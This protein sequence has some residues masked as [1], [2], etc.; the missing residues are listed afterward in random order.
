MTDVP[1]KRYQLLDAFRGLAILW[2][3]CF[4][5]LADVREQYGTVLNYI[6]AKGYLGV[7]IF[8]VISGY[9]V[10]ASTSHGT[11]SRKPLSFL[12]RRLKRIY[13]PYWWHL[14]FAVLVIPV[15][16][17]LVSMIK[18][19]TF[20]ISL[21]SYSILD[22][23]QIITLVKIFSAVNWK[24]N[25]AFLPLNGVVWY[26]AI[27]VQMYLF[28][29]ICFHFKKYYSS[30]LVVGFVASL[31]TNFTTIKETL[32]YGIFFP[33]FPQFCIG[34]F[35]FSLLRK[36]LVPE[37]KLSK[38]VIMLLG[39]GALYYCAS[40]EKELLSLSFAIVTGFIF[41][42]MHKYDSSLSRS[43]FVRLLYLMGTFSFSLYLLHVPL[44]PFVG[45][46][47]RNLVPLPYILSGP[48]IL[49]PGIIVLSFFWYLFFERP[50]T[51]QEIVNCIFCPIHTIRSGVKRALTLVYDR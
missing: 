46:F 3:V 15:L 32:P 27:I 16:S 8:F 49:V 38:T 42:I 20:D 7:S 40:N 44:W 12:S 5:V 37:T 6:I 4:H 35:V 51:Q 30:L 25:V 47:V 24:L 43:F 34:V 11:Y 48:F 31:L 22:W 39:I 9:G 14:L 33:Y 10:A 26:L 13:F 21:V 18:S 2:I 41:L 23:L 50:S 19:H 17:A 1:L 36:S 29:S 45:M 28:V